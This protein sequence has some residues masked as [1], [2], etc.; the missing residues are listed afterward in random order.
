M[1]SLFSIFIFIVQHYPA[2]TAAASWVR[3]RLLVFVLVNEKNCASCVCTRSYARCFESKGNRSIK[4]ASSVR[5]VVIRSIALC[6]IICIRRNRRQQPLRP[7]HFIF[8]QNNAFDFILA[9]VNQF[10]AV[11]NQ[12]H[13]LVP[14]VAILVE[15]RTCTKAFPDAWPPVSELCS[16]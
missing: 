13:A 15:Q 1:H 3:I 2:A 5:V 4:D 6:I 14:A 11:V 7:A 8:R 16:F 10:V 9:F 12:C